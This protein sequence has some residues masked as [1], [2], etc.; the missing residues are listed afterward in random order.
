MKKINQR[1]LIKAVTNFDAALKNNHLHCTAYVTSETF[2]K[3]KG[4]APLQGICQ[5]TGAG[6][7]IWI[8]VSSSLIEVMR[9]AGHGVSFEAPLPKDSDKLVGFAFIN[10]TDILTGDLTNTALTIGD[11]HSCM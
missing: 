3:N 1:L 6:P 9:D 8:T 7:T 10:N 2:M 11:V 5:G 4:T